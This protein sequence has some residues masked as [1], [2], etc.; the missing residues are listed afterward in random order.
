MIEP[1][2]FNSARLSFEAQ[3]WRL[4]IKFSFCIQQ[5]MDF[6]FQMTAFSV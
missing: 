2:I 5:Y 6:L 1:N 4:V 3:V